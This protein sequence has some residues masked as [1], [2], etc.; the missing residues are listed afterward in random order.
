MNTIEMTS[1]QQQAYDLIAKTNTSFFL[2][3]KAGSGKTSFLKKVQEEVNKNFIILAPTGVAAIIAGGETIHSFFG[4]PMEAMPILSVGRISQERYSV[5]QNVNT[6]IIDEVSMVRCDLIDAIDA[7]LRSCMHTTAPFGGKQMVFV[8]DLFQ[9]EPILAS[10]TDKEIIK[11]DYNTDKPF[12]FKAIVFNRL[13]LPSIEFNKV[14]RQDDETFLRILNNIRN[15]NVD[16]NGLEILNQRTKVGIP[17]DE[18]VI[19]LASI[20]KAANQINSSKLDAILEETF[21]FEATIL[22]NFKKDK[23]PVEDVLTLKKGAQVMFCRND[24]ARRW[25]NGSIGV[26]S[27][28]NKE[29]IHVTLKDGNEYKIEP[30][31][32]ESNSY[33]YDKSN[34][35]LEKTVNGSFTQYPLK[36]AWAIT[37]HKSQ[38]MT[39]DKMILDLS[40]GIFSDGQLYVALSRVKTLNG[41]YLTRPIQPNYVRGSKEVQRFA[42][43]FNN[44]ALIQNELEKGKQIF[45]FLSEHDYDSVAL[46]LLNMS[47][48]KVREGKIKEAIYLI[49]D[50]FNIMISD[51]HMLNILTDIPYL[52]EDCITCNMLNAVF[53]LYSGNYNDGIKYADRI[54][55]I[56]Q[57]KEIIYVKARCLALLGKYQDADVIHIQLG[58]II[59]KD[60]DLKVYYAIAVVNEAIGDPGLGIMQTV[61]KV[62]PKY[63]TSLKTLRKLMKDKKIN[64]F[65]NNTNELV[66]L[67]NSDVSKNGFIEAYIKKDDKEKKEFNKIV[68]NQAF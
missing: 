59:G 42:N 66:D 14:Y 56:H 67:F 57:S 35:K 27:K 52:K 68:L 45:K 6:I 10:A 17:E 16:Y 48:N 22:K 19:T 39:F 31:T 21:S 62:Q 55:S 8:G 46:E 5:L 1:K 51:E 33:K 37:I 43:Q 7:T 40:R 63:L 30:V 60:V 32:W 49:G 12:F 47:L 29:S 15:G 44:E 58:D 28:I 65:Y 34:R 18:M 26:V 36:L 54:I 50:M 11:E 23:A 64:L 9:L 38:G 61:F 3:G 13:Q 41:L 25:V 24:P 53:S 2:T 20:N 4:F